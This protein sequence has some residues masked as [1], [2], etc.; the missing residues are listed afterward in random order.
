MRRHLRRL[1]IWGA[2]VAIAQAA[3][4]QHVHT[5][6]PVEFDG[7]PGSVTGYI[8]DA[9][10][11]FRNPDAGTPDDA[12]ALECAQK[13]VLGGS[14]LIVWTDDRKMYFVLSDVIPDVGQGK[15]YYAYIG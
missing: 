1:V 11:L 9:A 10:C 5:H 8:R 14:P 6:K 2:A 12:V 3:L 15:K 7:R 13:C 4:A